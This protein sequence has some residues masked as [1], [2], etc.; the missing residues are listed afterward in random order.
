[1]IG[2]GIFKLQI[3][4]E[5]ADGEIETRRRRRESIDDLEIRLAYQVG[6]RERLN[7]P[8]VAESMNHARCA[9]L[10]PVN[11]SAAE[12][13]VRERLGNSESVAFLVQWAPWQRALERADSD[14]SYVRARRL[15]QLE[16][17]ALSIQPART[18]EGEWLAELG[19]LQ[20][21]QAQEINRITTRLTRELLDPA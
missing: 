18:T 6:L 14:G 15:H 11:L 13:I 19:E 7:L 5:I 10:S 12:N 1:M 4:D 17:D 2:E 9:N 8:A 16:R 21:R 3:L 20:Q